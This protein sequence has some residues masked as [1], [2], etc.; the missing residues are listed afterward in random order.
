MASTNETETF[1]HFQV[2]RQAD[3][4]LHELGRGAMGVTYKAFDTNLGSCV[5]LKVIN[6]LYLDN[7]A[8]RA[9][10]LREARAAAALHHRNI[11]TVYHLGTDERNFFFAMEF[12]DGVTL[13]TMVK[14][15]GGTVSTRDALEIGLQVSR[16][17]GAAARQG[18]VHRDIKPANIMVEREDDADDG[19]VVKVIDFGLVRSVTGGESSASSEM[20]GF[21][22]TPQYASPE[23]LQE[24]D[25]DSRSDIYSL[26]ITLWYLLA[27]RPPFVGP[28]GSIFI[29]QLTQEPPWKDLAD[30]PPMVLALLERLLQKD[31][32]RRP[33]SPVELRHEIEACLRSLPLP[34]DHVVIPENEPSNH[35]L[36]ITSSTIPAM[37][38]DTAELAL[39]P[40]PATRTVSTKRAAKPLAITTGT[41]L[42]DRY[43]LLE[44]AGQGNNGRVFRARDVAR[45]QHLFAVKVL[46]PEVLATNGERR[47]LAETIAGL[48]AVPHSHLTWVECFDEAPEGRFLVEE[49]I[50][51]FS[52][53]GLL[54]ARGRL[55]VREVIGLLAQL[56]AATDHAIKHGMNRLELGTHQILI[57]FPSTASDLPDGHTL[58]DTST[59]SWP[60]D[61]S[62]KL[63]ALGLSREA[64]DSATWGGDLTL[65]PPS[66]HLERD[67]Q[68]SIR[69]LVESSQFFALGM[70]TYELLNGAPP[71][72]GVGR[73]TLG[74]H[75]AA[76]PS[77]NEDANDVLRQ[78]LAPNPGFGSATEFFH[79]VC[80]ACRMAIPPPF[81]TPTRQTFVPSSPSTTASLTKTATGASPAR[82]TLNYGMPF[83]YESLPSTLVPQ[84]RS[85]DESTE[86]DRQAATGTG[87]P[88][89]T[90]LHDAAT[91]T[92]RTAPEC[93]PPE[94]ESGE[95]A[96]LNETSD[97]PAS[98]LFMAGDLIAQIP[99]PMPGEA[100]AVVQPYEANDQ[101]LHT[102]ETLAAEGEAIPPTGFADNTLYSD[103][104]VEGVIYE[105]LEPIQLT[106]ED[107]FASTCQPD[108]SPAE[109]DAPGSSTLIWNA[110]TSGND[111]SPPG[112]A[113]RPEP[114]TESL[115]A[116]YADIPPER[117]EPAELPLG[118]QDAAS[119][120]PSESP[121]ATCEVLPPPPPNRP[122]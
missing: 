91:E 89:N 99:L 15:Q 63:D 96:V 11:A 58:L 113:G 108:S 23:Q 101:A 27:G 80:E 59:E 17:L 68:T 61:F 32:A 82:E 20:G 81:A 86:D 36:P 41:Q 3:G 47:R 83:Q 95:S 16:A 55:P 5:A 51:G 92:S 114:S 110:T 70:V 121:Q 103:E 50:N 2:L 28:L 77:L 46:H 106:S 109:I 75:Y 69:G 52:L 105:P 57:H 33:Q 60:E 64:G 62:I 84:Y 67:T 98:A 40:L 45:D 7:E 90:V 29:Q 30:R 120:A 1:Q 102:A 21:L 119:C 8:A 116:E 71:T 122:F 111:I 13:D 115:F 10:F 118:T 97:G 18:L 53:V 42:A 19:F 38:T 65:I 72:T 93:R 44:L 85:A 48:R 74:M 31:P 6:A 25:L 117:H 79:A 22:G 37:A 112:V 9:R 39:E 43:D 100:L 12:V 35:V 104:S 76:L 49:W 78:M 94:M 54:R 66:S 87:S 56:A 34:T 26:G 88:N 4:T 14:A 73:D 24:R 107:G